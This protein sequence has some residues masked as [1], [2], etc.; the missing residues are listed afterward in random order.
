MVEQYQELSNTLGEA[1][2][3]GFRGRLLDRGVAR[4]LIWNDGSLPEGAPAFAESLTADLLD[5]A[6]SIMTMALRL[7]A[8]DRTNNIAKDAFLMAAEAIQAAVHR[9]PESSL[10]AGFHRINA[11][12]SYHLAGYSAMAYSMVSAITGAANFAPTEDALSMLFLRRLSEMRRAYSNWLRNEENLDSGVARRLREDVGFSEE[13]AAHTLIVTSFM[14]GLALFDHAISSGESDSAI[15]ARA[16]FDGTARIAASMDFVNHWWTCTLASHLVDDLWDLGLHQRL[17]NLPTD[18]PDNDD[19]NELRRNY[20]QTLLNSS[21]PTIELWPSQLAAAHRAIDPSDNLVVALPT[22]A[23]KT[24]IAEFCILRAVASY[25]RVIYVTPLRALS[26]Q[27]ERDLAQ[28]FV[29]LGFSVSSLYNLVDA[30]S[31]DGQTLRQGHIVVTTPEKLTFALRNDATLIDNVGLVILDEGHM[32]G[33]SEREVH[34]EVL[35]ETLLRREDAADRRIVSLSALFPNPEEMVDMVSWIRRDTPGEPIHAMWR[36]TRQ[37]FGTVQWLSNVARLD[38]MVEG[39]RSFVPRLI[40]QRNPPEGSLRRKPFPADKNELTL[41]AAWLF[42]EQ[43]RRV[44]IYCPIRTS[45]ETLGRGALHS[46]RQGLLTPFKTR[47]SRLQ[48]AINTGIEWLGEDHPAV[49]CLEHGIALHHAGLP[50]VFL[51][52]IERLL[53]LDECPLVI[54]SPT[55]AQGLNLSASVLIVPSIWRAQ[56]IVPS[57]E[58]ANVAG[59]SGRAFV[60]L[61]GLVLH[62]IWEDLPWR[63]RYALRNWDTLVQSSGNIRVTSGLLELVVQICTR[64]ADQA[65][66]PFEDVLDYITS[67]DEAWNFNPGSNV[68]NDVTR[69]DWEADIASL[70]S[71]ILALLGPEGEDSDI[72]TNLAKALDKALFSR[73]L[74]ARSQDEQ[75]LLPDLLAARARFIWT[76]TSESKRRGL[77][78][79]GIGYQAGFYLDSVLDDL[80]DLLLDAEKGIVDG[81]IAEVIEGVLRFASLVFQV[82]PFRPQRS[83]P[84]KWQ[85]GLTGWLTGRPASLVI[86]AL[87]KDGVDFLQ[88]GLTYRLPW[89][90]EAVR[91]HALAV[92]IARAEGLKGLVATATEAGSTNLSVNT[93]ISNGL[94]SREAARRAVESTG[95]SFN[96]RLGMEAW[97]SSEVVQSRRLNED[98]PSHQTRHEW[99]QFYEHEIQRRVRIWRREIVEAE[100]SWYDTPPAYG[101]SVVLEPN[102]TDEGVTVLSPDFR[103]IGVLMTSLSRPLSQAVG[104]RTGDDSSTIIVEFYGP[105]EESTAF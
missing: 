64:I 97:L 62:I 20:I 77:Y 33:P 27:V 81:S 7:R 58:F 6:Y 54:A 80:V 25:R 78:V 24:R 61:E 56:H 8:E 74:S 88:D 46:I 1:L 96:D 94:R 13:D 11:A 83:L 23:G 16:R 95:A 12:V 82:A 63:R 60:D 102:Q 43:G 44:F 26:A 72:K 53:R 18:D 76:R 104:A 55:L 17:P 14:R 71:A 86:S 89:A 105:D 36:P 35:V 84:E 67:D 66:V 22:S 47:N 59:R 90:M 3:P 34:Y 21:R 100:V 68:G 92:G 101:S 15:A 32:L 29:P 93:L 91:V 99:E 45:V 5:Y 85:E 19:W 73:V 31:G 39:Q 50:R 75:T 2:V 41:A 52:E 37:R 10:T 69:S 79:S 98:W 30:D 9:G 49:Q 57:T 40:E 28:T 87:G 42:V 4:S 51:S 48:E 38:M 65:N 103:E 70:D